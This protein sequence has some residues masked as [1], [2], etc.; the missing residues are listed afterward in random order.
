MSQS[1]VTDTAILEAPRI[2]FLPDPLG[3]CPW[4]Q[5][6]QL[7]VAGGRLC[8]ERLPH[9]G[10]PGE[11]LGPPSARRAGAGVLPSRREAGCGHEN[12]SP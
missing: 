4:R 3:G 1:W 8:P 11:G 2:P 10:P 12:L 7:S 6:H 9:V 5:T